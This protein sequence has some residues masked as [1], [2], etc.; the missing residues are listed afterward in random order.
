MEAGKGRPKTQ[1]SDALVRFVHDE[2]VGGA[3]LGGQK[4]ERVSI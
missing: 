1:V 3:I 2:A 4:K